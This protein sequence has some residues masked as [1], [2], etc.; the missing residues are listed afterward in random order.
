MEQIAKKFM[1]CLLTRKAQSCHSVSG[2]SKITSNSLTVSIWLFA[3][4]EIKLALRE[5]R[6]DDII[7]VQEQTALA[8]FKNT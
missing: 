7:M 4:T 1:L 8:K 3:F 6:C 2:P 5:K